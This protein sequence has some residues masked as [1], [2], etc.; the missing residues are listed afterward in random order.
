[1]ENLD[2][3][4]LKRNPEAISK[5]FVVKND[6]TTVTEEVAVIF[7]ERFI[8]AKLCQLGTTVNVLSLYAIVDS[9]ENYAVC[10]APIIQTL[11]PSINNNITKI[12]ITY[13]PWYIT[14]NN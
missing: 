2:I 8:N 11:S 4:S 1:M 6:I 13:I 5:L 3:K 12:F 9:N 7:P 10:S 14:F